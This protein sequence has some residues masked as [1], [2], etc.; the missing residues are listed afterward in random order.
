MDNSPDQWYCQVIKKELKKVKR[1]QW[2]AGAKRVL[3]EELVDKELV[4][5]IMTLADQ[6]HDLTPKKY[7]ELALELA[8]RNIPVPKNWKKKG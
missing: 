5:H 4:D 8:G 6:F 7:C 1:V 2:T 3:P